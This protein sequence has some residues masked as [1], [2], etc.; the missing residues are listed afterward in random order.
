MDQL[1]NVAFQ[2]MKGVLFQENCKEVV[3]VHM[4]KEYGIKFEEAE[5][6]AMEAFDMW[7]NAY[8]Y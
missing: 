5:K 8:T 3:I 1:L 7:S 6:L 4:M 2:K